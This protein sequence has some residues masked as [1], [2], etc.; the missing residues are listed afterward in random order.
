MKR[1]NIPSFFP[2]VWQPDAENVPP[3]LVCSRRARHG[4]V[5]KQGGYKSI[6]H[7]AA[8][9]IRDGKIDVL[10]GVRI[11][12]PESNWTCYHAP[13]I[14]PGSVVS[15][16]DGAGMIR[17]PGY[18]ISVT[19]ASAA[20]SEVYRCIESSVDEV[21]MQRTIKV[22]DSLLMKFRGRSTILRNIIAWLSWDTWNRLGRTLKERVKTL[23]WL[24]FECSERALKNAHEDAGLSIQEIPPK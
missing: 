20:L 24:G 16:K 18:S 9:A 13:E 4:G 3:I 23:E 11:K 15:K 21:S 17:F 12:S 19:A 6:Y 2:E 22:N 8:I 14:K 5:T 7:P 1:K 10:L